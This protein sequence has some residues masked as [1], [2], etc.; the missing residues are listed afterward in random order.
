MADNQRLKQ[1]ASAPGSPLVGEVYYDTV[2]DAMGVYT[3]S[4]WAYGSHSG[5][6]G[7]SFLPL[8]GGTMSG[9]I[10][11][12]AHKVT[13]LANGTASDDAAAFGQIPTALPPDGTAGGDLSGT[14]PNPGV[15]KLHG[16]AAAAV[17]TKGD[18]LVADATPAIQRVAVGADGDVLTADSTQTEGVKW[19]AASGGLAAPTGATD[20]T[21]SRVVGTAYQPS[22]TRP[23]MVVLT[24][25]AESLNGAP[26]AVGLNIGATSSPS[27][28]VGQLYLLNP[29]SSV[30]E[31]TSALTT[32]LPVGWY[33]KAVVLNSGAAQGISQAIEYT[34]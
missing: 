6:G 3:T 4:G 26:A 13:G 15:A 12:G 22:A 34:L 9:A 17:T 21:S 10:A 8:A 30:I 25:Y 24:L 20:V 31:V 16:I 11:M 2:L 23:V 29:F 5:W 18:L 19:A 14:Y 7:G 33:Y 32:I 27:T 28:Q 1:L